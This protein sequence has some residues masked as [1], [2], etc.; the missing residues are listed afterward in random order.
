MSNATIRKEEEE[1]EEEGEEDDGGGGGG[2]APPA[3]P[4]PP[5]PPPLHMAIKPLVR[6]VPLLVLPLA[7][8][9]LLAARKPTATVGRSRPV[10]ESISPLFLLL[11]QTRL[12]TPPRYTPR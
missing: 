1:E 3:V 7:P 4:P 10:A 11:V 9:P 2:A 5:P 6:V 8:L 12:L